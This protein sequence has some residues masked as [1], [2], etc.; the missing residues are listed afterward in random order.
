MDEKARAT[1]SVG[2]YVRSC[3]KAVGRAMPARVRACSCR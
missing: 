3:T 1:P 2:A